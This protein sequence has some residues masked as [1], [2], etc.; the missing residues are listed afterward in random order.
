[1][2]FQS[3]F[4]TLYADCAFV[5]CVAKTVFTAT[6]FLYLSAV[7]LRLNPMPPRMRGLIVVYLLH[8]G[9]GMNRERI[10]AY[11]Y[12]H[13]APQN[14]YPALRQRAQ[15]R[16]PKH[17]PLDAVAL[18][19]VDISGSGPEADRER[20]CLAAMI[21]AMPD[22]EVERRMREYRRSSV[23]FEDTLVEKLIMEAL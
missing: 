19:I 6:L 15:S 21:N 2:V 7:R 1:M 10:Q 13:A 9:G 18:E 12:K 22:E 5:V 17:A 3:G 16:R 14:E 8:Q 11:N 4:F 23:L 20:D